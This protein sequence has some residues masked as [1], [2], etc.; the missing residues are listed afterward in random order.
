MANGKV[1]LIADVH[2]TSRE[3]VTSTHYGYKATPR[4]RHWLARD[5]DKARRRPR[6]RITL[7]PITAL[8]RF[9][10]LMNNRRATKQWVV[11]CTGWATARG[12]R[13]GRRRWRCTGRDQ[14]RIR[15]NSS[16]TWRT[17]WTTRIAAAILSFGAAA[18]PAHALVAWT[19]AIA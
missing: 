7:A 11:P 15:A 18:A 10:R 5:G 17:R 4:L 6:R 1:A 13:T 9:S 2:E 12:R 19:A 8:S 16:K 3:R 14:G